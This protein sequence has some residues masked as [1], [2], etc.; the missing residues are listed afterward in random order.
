MWEFTKMTGKNPSHTAGFFNS[1][2]AREFTS[3][4][5]LAR[6]G[7]QNV[8]DAGWKT[9]QLTELVFQQLRVAADKK[10][11]FLRL[12]ELDECMSERLSAFASLKKHQRFHENVVKL[13]G[14]GEL[15][16]LLVRDFKTCGLGGSWNRFDKSDHFSRLVC[17]LNL[18][19]KADDNP[20]SGGSFGLGKTTYANSS[21]V[22]L[23]VYH[24]TFMETPETKGV[25][26]RLM[27]AGVFPEHAVG[28]ARYGGFAYQ[29]IASEDDPG[30]ANPFENNAAEEMWKKVS[31]LT[32]GKLERSDNQYGTDIL[33]FSPRVNFLAIKTAIEDFYWPALTK[34]MLSVRFIDLKGDETLPSPKSRPELK[35]F[36][37]LLQDAEK[38]LTLKTEKK[39]VQ[40]PNRHL[41]LNLGIYA[42]EACTADYA[43][44]GAK[45]QNT[46]A[47][48]RGTGMVINYVKLGSDRFEPA[49]GVFSAHEDIKMRLIASENAAHSEW[50][51]N[52]LRLVRQYEADGPS[53][54]EKVNNVLQSRF[55]N[56]QKDLQPDVSVVRTDSGLLSRL[57]S[58][59][60]KGKKGDP[61]P[62]RVEPNPVALSL[63]RQLR[64]GS[65]SSWVLRINENEHTPEAPFDLLISPTISIA[66]DSKMVGIK[67]KIITVKHSD[68]KLLVRSDVPKIEVTFERGLELTY[69]VE[70]P[71]PGSYNYVVSCKFEAKMDESLVVADS[72]GAVE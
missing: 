70:I 57:L 68:G 16:L 36:I 31:E 37:S 1:Y 8:I 33:I 4:E 2:D 47:L 29:G 66:G 49:V 12:F 10:S 30:S 51:K 23:V 63:R 27:S 19:N 58:D 6:E 53:T 50:N 55:Q 9:P 38:G 72:V 22:H 71:N 26:R 24:S 67:R 42:F 3:E 59:A 41:G 28:D 54:I 7:A 21:L 14:D 11:E 32:G 46:V 25:H 56:F 35:P 45:R 18:D 13:L 62:E 40:S 52:Q 43:E 15:D 69:F 64:E 34:R 44:I 61:R 65:V 20:E 48:L 5:V 17:A 39:I 60:L